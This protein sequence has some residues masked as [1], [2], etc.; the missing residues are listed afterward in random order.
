MKLATT[1]AD[2]GRYLDDNC[3]KIKELKK[4]GFKY[5]D[6]D[7][8]LKEDS[9]YMQDDWKAHAK[10]LKTLAKELGMEF[11]QAHA[12]GHINPLD[13]NSER[14]DLLVKLTNRSIELCEY[15]GIKNTVVHNGEDPSLS[16]EEWEKI[17]KEF[18]LKLLPT[19]EKCGVNILCENSA[20]CNIGG[21]FVNTAK[22]ILD[23]IKFVNHKNVHAC[24]DIGHGNAEGVDQY[25]QITML[26]KELYAIHYHDNF[27]RW[28]EHHV[29]FVGIVNHDEIISAL[30]DAEYKG[31][32]T[33]ESCLM[34]FRAR[35]KFDKYE[36]KLVPQ[37]FM[38]QKIEE[39][40]YQTGKYMLSTY[41]VFE[42]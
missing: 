30:I 9:V 1:T 5:I 35:R 24:W 41:N 3:D 16:K 33:F 28:D 6:L 42:E 26:G 13:K 4:A 25:E 21:H 29:P 39:L 23:F 2:F 36:N 38:Q 18:Y 15:L 27:G 7:M 37:L 14:V 10:K 20:K 34:F 40:I 22:D 11:V 17:N 12:P 31:Y 32:F 8:G 19:A